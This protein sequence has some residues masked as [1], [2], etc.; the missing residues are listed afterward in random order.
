MGK[1]ES[2][3]AEHFESGTYFFYHPIRDLDV[4]R[5]DCSHLFHA[6]R[7]CFL[8]HLLHSCSFHSF[9]AQRQLA[10]TTT[11]CRLAQK[12]WKRRQILTASPRRC[13]YLWKSAIVVVAIPVRHP[14]RKQRGVV[15][16]ATITITPLRTYAS[17]AS[18]RGQRGGVQ[19]ATITIPSPRTHASGACL[20]NSNAILPQFPK[21]KN[22][23]C[24]TVGTKF[25][26]L[27]TSMGEDVSGTLN[28][29]KN[30]G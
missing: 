29:E 20:K 1:N 11:N 17:G 16:C 2:F 9:C 21:G 15:L 8:A 6:I 28:E 19:C 23:S 4:Y 13:R 25:F 18:A 30:R 24:V 3:D 12:E 7:V 22:R 26:I 10:P 27:K 5:V 14:T